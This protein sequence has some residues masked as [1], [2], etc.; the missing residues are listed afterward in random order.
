MI[1][2]FSLIFSSLRIFPSPPFIWRL[3]QNC[4]PTHPHELE[5]SVVSKHL[6]YL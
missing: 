4:V 1:L 5:R 6:C 2:P 3:S